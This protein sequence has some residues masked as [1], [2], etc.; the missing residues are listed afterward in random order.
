LNI[1]KEAV[2]KTHK[3]DE[4]KAEEVAVGAVKYSFLKVGREQEIAFDIKESISLK[5]N[6]GPYLQYTH[7]RAQS[8]LRKY[9]A[10]STKHETNSKSEFSN[11]QNNA[12]WNK[13]YHVL[14]I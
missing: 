12:D 5:G 7:A 6:S 9:E 10:R 1:A 4:K 11:V 14:V 8:V 3:S 13:R 2:V